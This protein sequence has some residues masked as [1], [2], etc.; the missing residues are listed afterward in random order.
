MDLAQAAALADEYAK[1]GLERELA[2]LRGEWSDELEAAARNPDYRVPEGK[3]QIFQS[4]A[5]AVEEAKRGRGIS[6]AVAF[7]V[8]Q[9]LAAGTLARVPGRALQGQGTWNISLLAGQRATPAAEEMA[10]FVT[11]PR[12]TQANAARSR[13]HARTV[14]AG[15]A[16]DALEALAGLMSV[17]PVHR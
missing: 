10:R 8:A 9:D 4:H 16:R 14:Q 6:L 15:R 17:S 2:T 1:G 12:A 11:T 5:A 7:A 3:Q 13:G